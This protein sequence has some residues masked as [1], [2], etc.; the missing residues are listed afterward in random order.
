MF[1]CTLIVVVV[2]VVTM[3]I[4]CRKVQRQL[5]YL[6]T[7]S[8]LI[9]LFVVFVVFI[10]TKLQTASSCSGNKN[11]N[12]I[13]SSYFVMRLAVLCKHLQTH[14]H[15]LTTNVATYFHMQNRM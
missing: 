1:S 4:C 3:F 12:S 6:V 9:L 7:M 13:K 10:Y 8:L 5:R 11:N 14:R 15:T 2:V